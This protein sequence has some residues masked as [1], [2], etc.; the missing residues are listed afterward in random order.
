MISDADNTVEDIVADDGS[1][2][3]SVAYN[4]T[5]TEALP[6]WRDAVTVIGKVVAPHLI[7]CLKDE[8]TLAPV[9]I[10]ILLTND[11]EVQELN[12]DYREKDSATNVLSF[13]SWWDDDCPPSPAPGVPIV[14]GDLVLALE[15]L[16]AE[17]E[18]EEKILN[19]HFCHLILHGILHLIGYDHME[20]DEAEDME[21]LETQLLA[22]LGIADPH[23]A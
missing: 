15:T 1:W 6:G 8:G 16:E 21:S 14:L 20:D 19:D 4:A 3:I 9:E 7:Q 13:A 11:D 23:A 18:A 10:N 17:A 12:R 5:W 2:H 22:I